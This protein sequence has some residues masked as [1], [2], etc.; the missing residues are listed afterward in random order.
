MVAHSGRDRQFRGALDHLQPFPANGGAP[1]VPEGPPA[2]PTVGARASATAVVVTR[3]ERKVPLAQWQGHG[4]N[5]P[6]CPD[7]WAEFLSFRGKG[8]GTVLLFSLFFF[9]IDAIVGVSIVII[10]KLFLIL[11]GRLEPFSEF[12][13]LEVS[14]RGLSFKSRME[15]EGKRFL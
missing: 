10:R 4:K 9:S 8:G 11:L 3:R 5:R 13:G 12:L 7:G 14:V 15:Q 1:Q 6:L 2:C